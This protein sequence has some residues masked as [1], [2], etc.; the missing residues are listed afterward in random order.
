MIFFRR[1]EAAHRQGAKAVPLALGVEL[2]HA[3]DELALIGLEREQVVAALRDDFLVNFFS[4]SLWRRWSQ[5]S[6]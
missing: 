2:R 4:G 3:L 6:P 1:L 5:C